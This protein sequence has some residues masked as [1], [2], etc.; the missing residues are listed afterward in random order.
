VIPKEI[1]KKVRQ[2]EIRTNRLVDSALG[3]EYHSAFRGL[4][5]EFEEVREYQPGD[6]IRTIDWNVTART[7][8]PY[9]KRYREERE[10]T[11]VTLVDVSPSE[12]F[13]SGQQ[14]KA[15]L[16]AEFS[17]VI[18][19]S[20]IRNGDKVGTVLFTDQVEKYIPP[21]KGKKHVLR[22][23]REILE[24]RPASSGTNIEEALRFLAKVL[25]RRATV[26]LISDFIAADFGKALAAVRGK[27][28]V[29]AVRTSDPREAA[30][31][32]VGLITLEDAETGETVVV[33]SRSRRVRDLFRSRAEGER[34]QQ[35]VLLR[36][37]QIDELEI[38]TGSLTSRSF[39]ASSKCAVRR[40]SADALRRW[41]GSRRKGPGD[42]GVWKEGHGQFA[43][44]L[45]PRSPAPPAER[46]PRPVAHSGSR[47]GRA[48]AHH[49]RAEAGAFRTS[50]P[51]RG[52]RAGSAQAARNGPREANAVHPGRRGLG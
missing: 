10:L 52:S 1:L 36:S 32:D 50:R 6:E 2:I 8:S 20:A 42:G 29:I 5:M 9:V 34:V 25:K 17:A 43:Q 45:T 28:D 33:D 22:L 44:P 41:P 39:R 24:F 4:G 21:K 26:F 14:E 48:G 40:C 12:R 38:T 47:R 13:G 35:D 37:L 51:A 15:E 11:V 19:F 30:L 31:P 49:R 16:A 7:G 18:A 3:G 46:S 27:H 23:I